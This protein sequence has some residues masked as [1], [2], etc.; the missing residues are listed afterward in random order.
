[1][2]RRRSTITIEFPVETDNGEVVFEATAT[3]IPYVPARIHPVD[4]SHDAEGGYVEDIELKLDG[5]ELDVEDAA[6]KYGFKVSD[7]EEKLYE[8]ACDQDPDYDED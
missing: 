6:K 2:A 1:M 3:P 4:L 7:L 5:V 8:A